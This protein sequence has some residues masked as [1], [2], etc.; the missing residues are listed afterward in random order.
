MIFSGR[1]I[2]IEGRNALR[3]RDKMYAVVTG[4]TDSFENKKQRTKYR[5]RHEDGNPHTWSLHWQYL[6]TRTRLRDGRYSHLLTIL[7]LPDL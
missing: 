6:S 7:A 5:N 1:K 3:S 4:A 2:R